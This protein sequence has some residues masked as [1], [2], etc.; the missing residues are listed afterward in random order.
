VSALLTE[1]AVKAAEQEH[2]NGGKTTEILAAAVEA[3]RTDGRE[4]LVDEVQAVFVERFP[5]LTRD[6]PVGTIAEA[7]VSALV[8]QSEPGDGR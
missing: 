3:L 2:A 1:E 7:V 8:D 4:A 6:L 5:Y